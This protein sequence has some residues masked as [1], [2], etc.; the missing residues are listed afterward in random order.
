MNTKQHSDRLNQLLTIAWIS[1]FLPLFT[2]VARAQD[3]NLT[4]TDPEKGGV[5]FDIQGEYSGMVDGGKTGVQVIANGGGKFDFVVYNGGLPGDGW[6]KG[7]VV[8]GSGGATDGVLKTQ[9]DD[10][11]V[12]LQNGA[13]TSAGGEADL[14][15]VA[16]KSPTLGAKAPEG[17]VILFDGKDTDAWKDG[18][19]MTESGLLKAGVTSKE[20]FDAFQIHIEFRTPFKP[21]ARGQGRGNSGFYAQGRHEVQILDSFGLKGENNECGGIYTIASPAQNMCFPPLSWQTYDIDFTPAEFDA[22]GKKTKNALI[23]VKHNGVLIHE[24]VELTHATTASPLK[25]G[26]ESGPVYLQDHGNP[27]VYRNIWLVKK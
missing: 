18:A 9:V 15:K 7:E 19:K 17:A 6:D 8:R 13:I 10:V 1:A 22:E 12:T 11:E 16:R 3:T 23:S 25:E 20:V 4:I 14:K 21:F 2:L 27:V 5:D 24:N 26:K